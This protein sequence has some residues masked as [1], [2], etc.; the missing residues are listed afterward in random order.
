MEAWRGGV[1]KVPS[2]RIG[3]SVGTWSPSLGGDSRAYDK[4]GKG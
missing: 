2:F 1:A 4:F 3:H